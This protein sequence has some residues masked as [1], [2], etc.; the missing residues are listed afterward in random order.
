MTSINI[1]DRY[2]GLDSLYANLAANDTVTI[3][4]YGNSITYGGG[5]TYPQV[6]EGLL[7]QQY[8]NPNITVV[9]EGHPGWTAEMAAGGMDTLVL[10]HNPDLVTIIFGINDLYQNK[11]LA[12]YENNL[13]SM[14]QHLK[15]LGI[16]VLVM[17]PTPLHNT[18]NK[19]LIEFCNTA[20][21]VATQHDVAFF[22]MHSA[23][24]NRIYAETDNPSTI[25]PD[26]VH[27]T[28]EGYKYIGEE[29][30]K[31]WLAK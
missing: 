11:G 31:Y 5:T 28:D 1:P 6:F 18:S 24:V 22:N 17:S 4:C 8:N 13:N 29:L 16:P 20:D 19:A 15:A 21:A 9:N 7:R 2:T 30:M 12:N 10:P 27:Y 26:E 23:M 14:V 25:M 3:V